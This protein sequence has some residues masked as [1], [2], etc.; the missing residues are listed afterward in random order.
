MSRNWDVVKLTGTEY[1]AMVDE[2][3]ALREERDNWC[4]L[5]AAANADMIAAQQEREE[6]RDCAR[7]NAYRALEKKLNAEVA[8]HRADELALDAA[9]AENEKLRT[10]LKETQRYIYTD[11]RLYDRIDAALAAE[12]TQERSCTCHPEDNPPIPCPRKY[13]LAECRAAVAPPQTPMTE[14]YYE[15][16]YAVERKH[17]GETR[18][19]TALRYIRQ[20]EE[21]S[22]ASTQSR[23]IG[24]GPA[25][26]EPSS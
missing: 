19:E 21:A 7:F 14:L 20:A 5:A 16:L 23:A 22:R 11:T 15:L 8:M 2:R 6:A 18:H 10:L 9:R 17:P 13:A 12:P 3:D 25:R 1:D 4:A 24:I 26:G